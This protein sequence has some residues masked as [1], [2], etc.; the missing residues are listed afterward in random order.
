MENL[1][2]YNDD[3]SINVPFGHAA[4]WYISN[5]SLLKNIRLKCQSRKKTSELV[6]ENIITINRVEGAVDY[7]EWNTKKG[8]TKSTNRIDDVIKLTPEGDKYVRQIE[9]REKK[10]KLCWYWVM[11][12][13]ERRIV[14]S[15][16]VEGLVVVKKIAQII[17]FQII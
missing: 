3:D 11:Y 14:V 6:N 16:N 2:Q 17:F 9:A 5:H 1:I 12:C 15:V 4:E 10:D 13:Q 7:I 8:S